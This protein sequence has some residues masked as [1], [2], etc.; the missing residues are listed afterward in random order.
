MI[1]LKLGT[2]V[3][4]GE[5]VIKAKNYVKIFYSIIINNNNNN[6]CISVS[7]TSSSGKSPLLLANT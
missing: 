1:Q 5:K 6:D 4:V 3:G 2:N 7:N